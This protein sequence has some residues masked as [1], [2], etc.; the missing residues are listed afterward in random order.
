MWCIYFSDEQPNPQGKE[1]SKTKHSD[2][3]NLPESVNTDDADGGDKTVTSKN[4]Q[5]LTS[6]IMKVT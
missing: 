6:D 3:V 2:D 4:F 1:M 5:M